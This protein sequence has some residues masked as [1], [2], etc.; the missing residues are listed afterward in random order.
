MLHVPPQSS[1]RTKSKES[2]R[3][4]QYAKDAGNLLPIWLLHI[5]LLPQYCCHRAAAHLADEFD[6]AWAVQLQKP[7]HGYVSMQAAWLAQQ[8]PSPL[9]RRHVAA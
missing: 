1:S 9:G 7:Q 6:S 5:W 4:A 8:I 3:T 2:E